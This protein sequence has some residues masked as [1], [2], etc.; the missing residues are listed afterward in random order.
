LF[1]VFSYFYFISIIS[2]SVFFPVLPLPCPPAFALPL[3]VALLFPLAL[4]LSFSAFSLGFL[5]LPPAPEP[6]LPDAHLALGSAAAA[7]EL[8][9]Y[10]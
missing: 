9:G 2:S 4:P 3:P 10:L 6:A 8:S 1:L 7:T 5:V